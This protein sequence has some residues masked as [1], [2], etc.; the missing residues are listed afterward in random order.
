MMAAFGC[1]KLYKYDYDVVELWGGPS[2]LLALL[3]KLFFS[4][5]P[6]VHHSNGIEQHR[7]AVEKEL[8]ALNVSGCWYQMDLSWVYDWGLRV[9]DVIITVSEYDAQFVS[10]RT[11]VSGRRVESINNPLPNYFLERNVDFDRPKRVGFCGSW[12]PRKGV[13]IMRTDMS[14][15]LKEQPAWSFSVV[16]T[17]DADVVGE[18]SEAIRDRIETI[19][20]LPRERLTQWYESLAVLICPSIYESFGLVMAEAMACGAAVVATDTGFAWQLNDGEEVA[21]MDKPESPYLKARLRSVANNER[22]RRQL[23]RKGYQTVQALRW[24]VA[25][26][27]LEAIFEQ[28]IGSS[29]TIV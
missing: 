3:V 14:E 16:G 22:R 1:V 17:G 15:F 7:V 9:S 23:A 5:M 13:D 4:E 8:K 18:F 28:T 6:I 24:N 25:V 11:P 29:K 12:L 21:V 2:W 10:A 20:F 26:S 19:A 27:K